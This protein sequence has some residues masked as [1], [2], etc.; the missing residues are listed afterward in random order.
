MLQLEVNLIRYSPAYAHMVWNVPHNKWSILNETFYIPEE[1]EETV[2]CCW[3]ACKSRYKGWFCRRLQFMPI[4]QI[5][6]KVIQILVCGKMFNWFFIWFVVLNVLKCIPI[7]WV[8]TSHD[9]REGRDVSLSHFSEWLG[10]SPVL[11]CHWNRNRTLCLDLLV[12]G[13]ALFSF[14]CFIAS[15]LTLKSS[16]QYSPMPDVKT[17]FKMA[18]Q[19]LTH[20]LI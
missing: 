15:F 6:T 19:L 2:T 9:C 8:L 14:L 7:T 12:G 1:I 3:L 16:P 17:F 18:C 11:W 10:I 5:T 13:K 4:N 20:N